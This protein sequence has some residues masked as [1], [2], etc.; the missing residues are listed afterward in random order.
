VI[1]HA[2]AWKDRK[3]RR[4]LFYKPNQQNQVHERQC[5]E[6]KMEVLSLAKNREVKFW[7]HFTHLPLHADRWLKITDPSNLDQAV[8]LVNVFGGARFESRLGY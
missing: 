1:E 2:H 7:K 3:G 5:K 6:K 8:M 4:N